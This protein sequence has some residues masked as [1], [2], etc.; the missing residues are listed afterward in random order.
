MVGEE[1]LVKMLFIL[2]VELIQLQEK[3]KFGMELLGQ[4]LTIY[5]LLEMRWVLQ[6]QL[7]QVG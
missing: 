5:Q 3:L 4:K 6:E 2:Q 7:I 1:E